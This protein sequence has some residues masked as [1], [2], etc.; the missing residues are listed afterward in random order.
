M[1]IL[2]GFY[3]LCKNNP[4]LSSYLIKFEGK[5]FML[6]ILIVSSPPSSPLKKWILFEIEYCQMQIFH[7]N[8]L[9]YQTIEYRGK[10]K[11]NWCQDKLINHY[12]FA[13][14]CEQSLVL[15]II[16]NS[17]LIFFPLHQALFWRDHIWSDRRFEIIW[18]PNTMARSTN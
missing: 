15:M 14:L 3:A 7:K 1:K 5:N 18:C 13:L 9:K 17:S 8:K 2:M 10:C 12:N 4:K 16:G 11:G 6:W